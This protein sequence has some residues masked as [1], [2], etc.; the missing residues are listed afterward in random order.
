M[1]VGR[2]KDK[3][4]VEGIDKYSRRL[5]PHSQL[6]IIEIR[7]QQEPG[8]SRE[9][10]KRLQKTTPQSVFVLNPDGKTFTSESFANRI[11][12]LSSATF[13]IGGA[14]GFTNSIRK[15]GTSLSLSSLTFPHDLCRILLLEQLYRACTILSGHPYSK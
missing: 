4:L 5:R 12:P 6:E 8:L 10:L 15:T 3:T 14:D 13:L 11:K 7:D 1:V 2:L 9:L